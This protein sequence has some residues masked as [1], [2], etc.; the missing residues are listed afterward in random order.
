MTWLR[1]LVALREQRRA[2]VLV[3]VVTV[4]G[5]AP[6]EA[7]AKLVVADG[8]TWG[9]I[10][11]GNLEATAIERARAMLATGESAPESVT[12]TLSDHAPNEHGR[13]CC[14][15]EVTFVLEPQGVP[16]CVAIAGLGH[17]G[18]ELARVLAR[19]DVELHLIDSRAERV[20]A[21]A[22]A[23]LADAVADVR[24]HHA[25]APESIVGALPPG[26]HLL[27][28][29]HDH[30]ED[31]VVCDAALRHGH[32]S[33]VGLIG[34]RTKAARFARLLAAEG[35]DATAVASVRCPIGSDEVRG[36]EPATI[37]LSVALEILRLGG[38]LSAPAPSERVG[39]VSRSGTRH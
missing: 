35:H 6:R 14:G 39:S 22:L 3:T 24:V 8:G 37:A 17:V 7:G 29:T 36:K 33:S 38:L 9:T 20:S 23:P 18:I 1:A 34:S 2:A 4:R 10:G 11:G 26:A 32:L 5:H 30:A 19:H 27:V 25:P 28:M 15:G 13:Q 12:M 31:L 16:P 21:A